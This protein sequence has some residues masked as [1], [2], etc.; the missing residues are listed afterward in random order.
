MSI[1]AVCGFPGVGKDTLADILVEKFGY[2][3]ISFAGIVKDIV[4]IIFDWD[5]K[6]L[7]GSTVESRKWREEIDPWWSKRLNLPMLSPR[8]ILQ[9]IGTNVFRDNFHQD[10][11]IAALERKIKNFTGV[12][13]TDLRFDN[14]INTIRDLGGLIIHLKNNNMP[15]W[16]KNGESPPDNLH[17]SNWKWIYSK[18]DYIIENIGTIKDLEMKI[19]NFLKNN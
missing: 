9:Q 19:I 1:I 6:M 14:E 5:R 13:I 18:P 15:E 12:V 3:K 4:S 11:W 17:P 8:W 2:T 7:E 16:Y 10:I